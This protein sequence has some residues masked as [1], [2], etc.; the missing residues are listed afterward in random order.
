M[1]TVP[2]KSAELLA[3]A[4]LLS[5]HALAVSQRKR[6]FNALRGHAPEFGPGHV[7]RQQGRCIVADQRGRPTG[8]LQDE[9]LS[10]AAVTG[11]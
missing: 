10:S 2:V 5:V 6:L 9:R 3:D 4:M 8:S 1:R 11:S 7:H